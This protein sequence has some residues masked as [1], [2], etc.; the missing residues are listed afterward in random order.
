LF[1]V[2]G[3]YDRIFEHNNFNYTAAASSVAV[4]RV[5]RT[6]LSAAFAAL[7]PPGSEWLR[8]QKPDL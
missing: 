5:G 3:N 2:E 7:T 8:P 4:P 6:L 1:V